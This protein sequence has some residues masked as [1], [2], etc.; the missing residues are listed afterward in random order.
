MKA[1]T[2]VILYSV[3]LG[4]AARKPLFGVSDHVIPKP[5]CAAATEAGYKTANSFVARL[6]IIL[7][8]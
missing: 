8:N 2:C 5:A 7:S 6:D 4:I 1:Y 3:D